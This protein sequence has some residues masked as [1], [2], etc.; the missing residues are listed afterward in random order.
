MATPKRWCDSRYER[1]RRAVLGAWLTL[2]GRWPA[3]RRDLL[4]EIARE[5][6]WG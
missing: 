1:A 6:A 3:R 2:F 4:W 5:D